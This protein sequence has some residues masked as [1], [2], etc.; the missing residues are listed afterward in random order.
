LIR[1]EAGYEKGYGGLKAAL[2]EII[3][4]EQER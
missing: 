2:P 4:L 1:A 3:Q